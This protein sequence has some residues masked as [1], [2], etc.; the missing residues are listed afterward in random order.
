M[1]C[2]RLFGVTAPET[3]IV[4]LE[5]YLSTHGTRAVT[6]LN[7][8]SNANF[9]KEKFVC[10]PLQDYIVA[11]NGSLLSYTENVA[12]AF[13]FR[14]STKINYQSGISIFYT[15]VVIMFG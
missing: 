5:E 1:K 13:Q 11:E 3:G 8:F 2:A 6:V 15:L 4:Y 9:Q 7:P 10:L 12:T 14:H